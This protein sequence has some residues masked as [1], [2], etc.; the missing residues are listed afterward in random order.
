MFVVYPR[1]PSHIPSHVLERSMLEPANPS[2]IYLQQYQHH[3]SILQGLLNSYA[4]KKYH[5]YLRTTLFQQWPDEVKSRGPIFFLPITN[6]TRL[7][8]HHPLIRNSFFLHLEDYC[9]RSKQRLCCWL[10]WYAH[11]TLLLS[12]CHYLIELRESISLLHKTLYQ[13]LLAT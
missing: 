12:L 13:C 8:L 2:I 11:T 1:I 9:Q 5:I 10:H 3:A 7:F 4:I 6:T